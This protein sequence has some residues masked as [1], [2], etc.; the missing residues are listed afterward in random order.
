MSYDREI[1]MNMQLMA[2]YQDVNAKYNN[3][4]NSVK[5]KTQR[6][7]PAKTSPMK[8]GGMVKKKK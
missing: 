8:C 5:I 1:L 2:E 4:M 3:L 6:Q 7:S